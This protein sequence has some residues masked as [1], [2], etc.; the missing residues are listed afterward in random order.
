M[1]NNCQKYA[2]VWSGFESWSSDLWSH[3]I[4]HDPE[5]PDSPHCVWCVEVSLICYQYCFD[6]R[7]GLLSIFVDTFRA[8]YGY[9]FFYVFRPKAGSSL[10][11][12]NWIHLHI[13]LMYK[14]CNASRYKFIFCC[15]NKMT[16]ERNQCWGIPQRKSECL[17]RW[18]MARFG[19]NVESR[20]HFRE[21]PN[22]LDWTKWFWY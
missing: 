8:G 5:I 12:P 22:S 6:I 16:F 17:L 15:V 4:H 11:Q 13:L 19:T 1:V 21:P 2:K 10:R 7:N 18:P 14:K 20:R 9:Y 3:P